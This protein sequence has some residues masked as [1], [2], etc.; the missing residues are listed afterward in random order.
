MIYVNGV[1]HRKSYRMTRN[2]K[3]ESELDSFLKDIREQKMPS[4]TYMF[5]CFF[6]YLSP[7]GLL[8]VIAIDSL[9]FNETTLI[10]V[11]FYMVP[12]MILIGISLITLLRQSL[13]FGFR[14]LKKRHIPLFAIVGLFI[15]IPISLYALLTFRRQSSWMTRK[16]K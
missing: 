13:Y 9:M 15:M 4:V 5:K 16:E 12:L 2:N 7:I 3:T 1:P 6:Y 10:S 8:T 11:P 14:K